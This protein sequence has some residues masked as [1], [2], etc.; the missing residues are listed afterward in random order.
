MINGL[1]TILY[2]VA[3]LYMTLVVLGCLRKVFLGEF[4]GLDTFNTFAFI[5]C[6]FALI[7]IVF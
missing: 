6:W 3:F 4:K 1:I 7:K 5:M 2:V